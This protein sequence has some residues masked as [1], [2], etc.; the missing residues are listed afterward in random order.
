MKLLEA[1]ENMN[2]QVAVE[3]S[4]TF[5]WSR[6]QREFSGPIIEQSLVKPKQCP[7]TL[8]STLN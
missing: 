6:G 7:I 3:L 5:D 8:L 1:R 2:D 4:F